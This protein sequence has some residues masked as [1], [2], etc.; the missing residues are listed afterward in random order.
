M[1]FRRCKR[2]GEKE[3]ETDPSYDPTF[4]CMVEFRDCVQDEKCNEPGD[5][6]VVKNKD[7]CDE[8]ARK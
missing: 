4:D 6:V 3:R 8:G 5:E 2:C 7:E 1:G